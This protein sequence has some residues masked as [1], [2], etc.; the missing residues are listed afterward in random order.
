MD[1]RLRFGVGYQYDFSKRTAMY[2]SLSRFVNT[3]F[4]GA[5]TGRYNGSINGLTTASDHSLS[6]FALGMRHS[7]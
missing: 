7:F 6:E 5:N 4:V 1:Y 3:G 2:T